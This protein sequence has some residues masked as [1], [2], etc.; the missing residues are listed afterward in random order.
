MQVQRKKPQ[1]VKGSGAADGGMR[2]IKK[3]G[4]GGDTLYSKDGK[5]SERMRGRE[6]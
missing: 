6:C 2:G 5:M 4:P 1:G 3:W